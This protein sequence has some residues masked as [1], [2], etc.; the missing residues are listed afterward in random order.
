MPREYQTKAREPRTKEQQLAA[1][2][3]AVEE[4]AELLAAGPMTLAELEKAVNAS[5]Q[6]LLNYLRYMHKTLRTAH[7]LPERRGKGSVWALGADPD[8]PELEQPPAEVTP[9]RDPLV[10]ALFGAPRA[11]HQ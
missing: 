6:T 5:R 9:H 7:M 2:A 10:A 4:I 8:L 11:H 3:E 1:R